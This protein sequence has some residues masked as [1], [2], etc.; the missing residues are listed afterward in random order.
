MKTRQSK[1][2]SALVAATFLSSLAPAFA[3]DAA[4]APVATSDMPADATAPAP[5]PA[6]PVAPADTSGMGSLDGGEAAPAEA[7]APSHKRSRKKHAA[8]AKKAKKK[9]K[10]GKS[11]AAHAKKKKKR[12]HH[13]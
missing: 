10:K 3:E 9:N 8:H 11:G 1:L 4:T 2:L 7:P 12:K 5:D 6:A 13:N